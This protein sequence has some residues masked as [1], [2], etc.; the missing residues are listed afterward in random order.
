MASSY[1]FLSLDKQPTKTYLGES[2]KKLSIWRNTSTIS[3]EVLS[4]QRSS[5]KS[6]VSYL[7]PELRVE[8]KGKLH[9]KPIY[10]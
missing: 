8:T 2:C 5:G 10:H 6:Y 7:S 4:L 3:M 9:N 1:H